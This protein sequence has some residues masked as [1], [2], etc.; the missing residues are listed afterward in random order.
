MLLRPAFKSHYH[1]EEIENEGIVA[2]S[3]KDQNWL[4]GN[5]IRK[6]CLLMDGHRSTDEIVDLLSKEISLPEIYYILQL[7]E[8]DG[9]LIEG[10]NSVPESVL[11]FWH[12]MGISASQAAAILARKKVSF[13]LFGGIR[14]T[15][16]EEALKKA[17]IKLTGERESSDLEIVLTDD[18]GYEELR[19]L[20]TENMATGKHWMLVKPVG[21]TVWIGPNIRPH[22]TACWACLEQRIQSNRQMETYVKQKKNSTGPIVTSIASFPLTEEIIANALALEVMKLLVFGKNEAIDGQILSMDMNPLRIEHHAVVKR[23]QCFACGSPQHYLQERNPKPIILQP[24]IKRFIAEGGHRILTP[25]ETLG[26]LQHHVSSIS[27]VVSSL[28][29]LERDGN[30]DFI[31]TYSAGHNFAIMPTR[32]FDYIIKNIRGRSGGKGT[33][34]MQAKVSGLCE[35]IERYSGVYRGD[36]ISRMASFEELGDDAIHPNT[37]MRYSDHQYRERLAWNEKQKSDNH[38]VPAVFDIKKRV[39]WSPVYSLVNH[40]FK[41]VPT[42]FCYF[43]HPDLTKNFDTYCDANGNG[44]GNTLEEAILQGFL[45]L[46]E[47]D[48]V[49]IWWYNRVKVPALDLASFS[50]PYIEKFITYYKS[51]HRSIWVLDITNDLGIPVFAAISH[52]TDR[53]PQ[54]IVLGFGAHLDPKIA[55]LR[56]LT[57]VNQFIPCVFLDKDKGTTDYWFHDPEAI[58]WWMTA[59]LGSEPYLVPRQDIPARKLSDF[60]IRYSDDLKKDVEYCVENLSQRGL[61]TFVLDQSRPDIELNV[62]KVIVPGLRHFWR[63]LGEGRLYD[64]PVKLG[65]LDRPTAETEFNPIGVFF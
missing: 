3:E 29:R 65:W 53:N 5:K 39:S 8:N 14:S 56:A 25:E 40:H 48:A 31:F 24:A 49:A 13:R 51:I 27:G 37:I 63:R 46:I 34:Q 55:L 43:G 26:K 10:E 52:R 60:E 12:S 30:S 50:D 32:G 22:E 59:T 7:L 6:V 21:N 61:E 11:A 17:S 45:E 9:L 19:R 16:F 57:E 62:V 1:I 47:R 15:P 42:S 36:E 33:T 64:V 38:L 18:Y 54:D 28:N 4:S 20:N 44:A 35:A 41:Y 58:Y 2:L 23:P